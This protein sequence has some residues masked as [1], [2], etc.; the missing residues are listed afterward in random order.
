[1]TRPFRGETRAPWASAVV[2]VYATLSLAVN[3]AATTAQQSTQTADGG[4]EFDLSRAFMA[5]RTIFEPLYVTE[6][7]PLREALAEDVVREET[8]L[9]IVERNGERL[10]LVTA[11]MAY[12]HVAQGELKGEPW[13]VSF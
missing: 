1:M 13:M 8:R 9:L 2:L 6:T 12:H 3:A 4:G 7:R 5:K 11:Q 10:A